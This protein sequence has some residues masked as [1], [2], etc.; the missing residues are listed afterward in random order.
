MKH[1]DYLTDTEALK[2]IS[3]LLKDHHDIKKELLNILPSPQ[4]ALQWL[5]NPKAPL[6]NKT[7]LS[8][9]DTNPDEVLDI[10]FRIKTGD[11]S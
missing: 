11:F 9:I 7:P 6:Q 10:L 5:S 3:E 4:L 2:E 8:L 1:F